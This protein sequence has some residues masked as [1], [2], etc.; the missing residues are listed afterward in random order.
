MDNNLMIEEINEKLMSNIGGVMGKEISEV[1]GSIIDYI[2]D[3]KEIAMGNKNGIK[4]INNTL[5]GIDNDIK[6]IVKTGKDNSESIN[7]I[8]RKIDTLENDDTN[9][10]NVYKTQAKSRVFQL[11]GD[12]S[13]CKFILFYN[14][15]IS[16][17]HS[18]VSSSLNA[19]N[20]KKIYIE[21]FMK[22]V[23]LARTWYPDKKY[24]RDKINEVLKLSTKKKLSDSQQRKVNALNELLNEVG[25]D[26][27]AI[28]F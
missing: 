16:K 14:S 15:F 8:S 4:G 27:N 17:L 5:K 2:G 6:G 28:E 21:D 13:N 11:V 9:K 25:G 12:S 18:H 7:A 19:A 3:V 26:I 22:A 20:T 23:E 1:I 10:F 24:I